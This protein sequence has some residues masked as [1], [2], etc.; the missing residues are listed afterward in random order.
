MKQGRPLPEVLLG[1]QRQDE[2][3]FITTMEGSRWKE[4]NNG[5]RQSM[6][7]RRTPV[8]RESAAKVAAGR[9][10]LKWLKKRLVN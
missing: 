7:S 5:R 2:R 9:R 3:Y 1:L 8:S 4:A 6:A 10:S